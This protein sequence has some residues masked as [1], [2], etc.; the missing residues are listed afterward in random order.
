VKLSL[1]HRFQPRARNSLAVT[2]QPG[3]TLP[4]EKFHLLAVF[5]AHNPQMPGA[6]GGKD[7]IR[8]PEHARFCK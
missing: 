1:P 7:G 8:I 2:V 6:G 5:G 4:V 3:G